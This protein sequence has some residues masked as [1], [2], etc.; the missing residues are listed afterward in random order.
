MKV[1]SEEDV[2]EDEDQEHLLSQLKDSKEEDTVILFS[3]TEDKWI[4]AHLVNNG[5]G[6][7]TRHGLLC[8]N[9]WSEDIIWDG[10][11]YMFGDTLWGF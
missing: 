5:G 6:H 9:F 11:T 10:G 7:D 2:E 1:Y 4:Q 3:L 8:W